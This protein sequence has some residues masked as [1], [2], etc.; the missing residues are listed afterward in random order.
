MTAN[1]ADSENAPPGSS[2]G[3]E[4]SKEDGNGDQDFGA[5]VPALP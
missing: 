4:V 3:K 5:G 2:L 1:Q